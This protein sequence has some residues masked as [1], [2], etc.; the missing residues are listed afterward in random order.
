VIAV[1]RGL[2]V[3]HVWN[4]Q[5]TLN[6]TTSPRAKIDAI[7]GWRSL[8]E[9]DDSS[10]NLN[11]RIG[12]LPFPVSPRGK[13]L[14]YEGRLQGRTPAE[15]EALEMS[16][17]Y[18]FGERS[19]EGTMTLTPQSG[20]Y[21]GGEAWWYRARVAAFE[22]DDAQDVDRT[23]PRGMWQ[24]PYTLTLHLFDPRFY[25]GP[26]DSGNIATGQAYV[27]G[28]VGTAPADPA[29]EI[30][31]VEEGETAEIRNQ[32][33]GKFL[34][35]QDL[36]AGTLWVDFRSRLA[37]MNSNQD[38]VRYLTP[39]SN[40]WDEGTPG[41]IPGPNTVQVVNAG[42]NWHVAWADASW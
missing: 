33:T 28:N 9:V 38:A 7:R 35:F 15:L 14:T 36:P 42:V 27:A 26:H 20:V 34:Q 5:A 11:G 10:V 22:C 17:Q 37:A 40:W 16:L 30:F 31:N 39:E 2:A 4:G 6:N 18:A 8:P 19:A 1:P 29:F 32:T 13:T 12:Q 21:G 23:H 41:L 25:H 24:R 3:R